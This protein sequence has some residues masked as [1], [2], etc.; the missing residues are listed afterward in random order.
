MLSDPVVLSDGTSNHSYTLRSITDGKS[1]RADSTAPFGAPKTLTISHGLR[2]PKDPTSPLR[3][4]VRLD[5]TVVNTDGSK[6]QLS[7][8]VVAEIPQTASWDVA[9]VKLWRNQINSLLSDGIFVPVIN[10]EL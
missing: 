3:H 1:I 4:L 6:E 9:T 5:D 2:T 8:Y 7:I 10:G